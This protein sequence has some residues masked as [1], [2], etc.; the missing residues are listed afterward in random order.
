MGFVIFLLLIVVLGAAGYATAIFM[1]KKQTKVI[2][3]LSEKKDKLMAV[4]IADTFYTLKNLNLT[5]QT[6]RIDTVNMASYMA[7][8]TRFR[9]PE[10]EAALVSAEQYIQK[11]KLHQRK[12]SNTTS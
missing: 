10:I 2:E 4:P 1:T 5:G 12:S 8:I 6:K 9:F 11:F 3:E 7:N